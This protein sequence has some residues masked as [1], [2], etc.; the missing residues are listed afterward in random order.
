MH[1]VVPG[2]DSAAQFL[3]SVASLASDDD[4]IVGFSLADGGCD[5]GVTVGLFD[6]PAPKAPLEVY[7]DGGHRYVARIVAGEDHFVLQVLNSL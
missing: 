5:G 4:Q 6:G 1:P 3:E 7:E 2:D